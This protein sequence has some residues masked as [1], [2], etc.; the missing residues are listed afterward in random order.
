MPFDSWENAAL[1]DTGE[2]DYIALLLSPDGGS[3]TMQIY[4]GEKGK[5]QSGVTSNSFLARNGLAF[6]SWYYLKASYPITGD[7]NAGGFDTSILGALA[8]DKLEDVD[9][10]P[11]DPTRAV[12]GD[13]TSGVFVF[14]FDLVFTAGFNASASSFKITKISDT[15]GGINSLNGP[16]NIDWTRATTLGRTLYPDG[17]IFVNEDNSSGEIWR[18]TPDGSNKLRIAS[19]TVSAES[20]GILDIS[21]LIAYPPGSIILTNNQGFPSS[22]SILINPE[23][24]PPEELCYPI[25]ASNQ[26]MAMI[27]L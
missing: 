13:Q 15:S 17:L 18:M 3:E 9:T 22:M 25:K 1:L 20:T 6:G 8:S 27:C 23:Y 14:D 26:K 19:T 10:N 24:T 21:E 5:D 16:D 7:S 4:I 12:L 11:N 2:T